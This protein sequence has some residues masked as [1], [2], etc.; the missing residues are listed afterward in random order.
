MT[1]TTPAPRSKLGLILWLCAIGVVV[2]SMIVGVVVAGV[3]IQEDGLAALAVI[4]VPLLASAVYAPLSI[5]AFIASL[6]GIRKPG[7]RLPREYV[8]VIGSGVGSVVSVCVGLFTLLV[9]GVGL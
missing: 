9:Y 5:A 2:L 6:V 4:T 7:V 8:V 3:G 1:D